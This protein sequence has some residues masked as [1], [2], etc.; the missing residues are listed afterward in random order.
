MK[1]A[2]TQD[3]S[4]APRMNVLDVSALVAGYRDRPVLREVT[5]AV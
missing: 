4:F 3:A 5:F 2:A 1:E